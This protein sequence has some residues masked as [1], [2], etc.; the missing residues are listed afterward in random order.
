MSGGFEP[1]F[2]PAPAGE[3]LCLFHPPRAALR[4][5]VLYLHPFAEEMNKSR[6]MAALGARALAA[7]GC[8][9]L[10][11]DLYG[12]GDSSGDFGDA[13]WEAWLE[14][15][16]LA[17][18]WLR[19]RADAPLA[20]WGL[21]LGA[22]LALDAAR[23]GAA[24]PERFL[25]WQP[26]ASGE[27]MLTQF[28]RLR[29]AGEMLAEGKAATG[30]QDLRSRLAAGAAQEI[31]GYMLSPALAASIDALRLSELRPARGAVHWLEVVPE[32]GRA[33]TP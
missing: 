25:L 30:V 14:D 19:A 23:Q 7:R 26:V 6:R 16:A 18:G 33:P 12:C 22:L 28:L 9:V 31:A 15:A 21:R 2:L 32:A 24:S 13:S 1:F 4:A 3:R 10:Q 27:A 29:V 20:L 11:I 5:A 8:A 17:L